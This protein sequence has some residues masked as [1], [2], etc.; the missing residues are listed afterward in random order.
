M[1]KKASA[2]K[3]KT[4]RPRKAAAKTGRSATKAVP[5]KTGSTAKKPATPAGDGALRPGHAAVR[6]Y[7]NILGDCFLV[8]FPVDGREMKILIDCGALQGMPD[9]TGIMQEIVANIAET[10]AEDRPNGGKVSRLDILVATHE[11]VDH[12]SGFAQARD[13]F[14][15][16]EIGELWLAWTEDERD[17]DA[18]KIR[19]RRRKTLDLLLKLDG[20]ISSPA[21]TDEEDFDADESVMPAQSKDDIRQL[22]AFTEDAELD[23]SSAALLGAAGN[24]RMTTGKILTY[25]KEKA[26]KV[27][28]FVPGS[29]PVPLATEIP[30]QVYVLGP[31]KDEK[32]LKRSNPRKGEVYLRGET[33][34]LAAYL[35]A[36]IQLD[37]TREM[38]DPDEEKTFQMA[39]PFESHH[40]QQLSLLMSTG[41]AAAARYFDGENEWRKIDRDWLRAAEQLALKL[42][43]DTNNTSLVLAFV[44]G[45][46]ADR[47][48]MLFPGDAQVGNWES[49][50]QYIWPK[51]AKRDE[52]KSI[53]IA[54]LLASTVLYKVGHHASHNATLRAAGLE[55]MTHPELVAMIPVKEEFARKTKGWNMPFPAL[56]S[57][58]MEKTKGRV[59]RADRS[60]ADLVDESQR[61]ANNAGEM[62][63][64]EWGS[65]LDR[66]EEGPQGALGDVPLFV[67]YFVPFVSKSAR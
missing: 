26:E 31:P 5:K 4:A 7:N 49:W 55:L 34:D 38:F 16:I 58:L 1:A 59:L 60:R 39:M 53:A 2:K 28:Y 27:R 13:I 32:L 52:P 29:D 23:A 44:V 63:S 25:L 41:D 8:R 22:F 21:A 47:R 20:H 43:S 3:A 50:Q 48:V 40:L 14:D 64:K 11:H 61:R 67:E 66:V 10:T 19:A 54:E 6:M 65:F 42:D 36:A 57:R 37:K 46:G 45:E 9:A 33:D 30:V 56:L 17:P 35:A 12:L 18:A 24:G 62:S 51:G 15:G